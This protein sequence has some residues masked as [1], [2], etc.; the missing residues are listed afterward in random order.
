MRV[1]GTDFRARMAGRS[2]YGVS[3]Y[4]GTDPSDAD[5]LTGTLRRTADHL[6][7]GWGGVLLGSGNRPGDVL[8][9]TDARTLADTFLTARLDPH[10]A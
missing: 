5:A 10:A 1:P 9:D 8:A 2:L 7:M 4:S 6:A 3:A